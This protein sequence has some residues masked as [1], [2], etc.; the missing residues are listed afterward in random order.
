MEK[1]VFF[2]RVLLFEPKIEDLK[3]I[4]IKNK[5][6]GALGKRSKLRRYEKNK[7]P[8]SK[9]FK[10]LKIFELGLLFFSLEGGTKVGLSCIILCHLSIIPTIP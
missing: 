5:K 8:N 9:I 4:F 2:L 1:I 10:Y 3:K 6:H 7:S